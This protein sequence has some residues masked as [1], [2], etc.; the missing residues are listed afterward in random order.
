MPESVTTPA[1]ENAGTTRPASSNRR[2]RYKT[3]RNQNLAAMANSESTF[4]G[5]NKKVAIIGKP[6]EKGVSFERFIEDVLG[7]VVLEYEEGDDLELLLESQSDDFEKAAD[8][9]LPELKSTEDTAKVM[10]EA[11]YA[12]YRK[13]EKSYKNN[14]KKLFGLIYGQCT[15]TLLASIKSQK[16]YSEKYKEKDIVWLL[17]IIKRL[18]VGIDDNANDLLTAHDAL[19]LFYNMVQGRT[20]TNE[21]YMERFKETWN[22]A[23]ATSGSIKCLVPEVLNKSDKYKDLDEEAK[24]EATKALYYFIHA[25]RLRYG[26]KINQVNAAVV[27]G[28]DQYPTTLDKAYAILTETQKQLE[29][30][31][32]RSNNYGNRSRNE[33]GQSNYQ[34]NRTIPDGENIVMG[35]DRR[36]FNVQCNRCNA[37]GHYASACPQVSNTVSIKTSNNISDDNILTSLCYI[38]DTGSTHTTVKDKDDLINLTNLFKNKVLNMRSSTGNILRYHQKGTLQ[39]FGVESYYNPDTAANILAFHSLSKLKDAYMLYDSRH[40][41]CFRLI[42]KNGK[43]LQFQNCGDGLY[44]FVNPIHNKVFNHMG[45]YK[46]DILDMDERQQNNIKSETNKINEEVREQNSIK[47]ETKNT[48]EKEQK[49]IIKRNNTQYLQTIKGNE[50][51]MTNKERDRAKAA[52]ELQEYLGWPSTQEYINIINGNE[53]RNADVTVDDIKRALTLFGEPT[54]CLR[55]KMTRRRPLSHDTL[56]FVQQPLPIQLHDKRVELY[57]DLYKFAGT[58]FIIME[59]SRIKYIDIE[60][61]T[62]QSIE[63]LI[64]HVTNEIDKYSARGLQISGVHVDNQFYKS[65]FER[66]IKPA[67]LIPYAAEEHVSIIERR[68][69]TVKERMRSILSGLPYKALPNVMI[70]GLA[71]K[72]KSML[73]KFPARN[74]GVSKTISPEEI[75]EGKRKMDGNRKRINFGQF[76]EIHDGTTNKADARSVGGIAMYATN[77][78]EGFA[79]MCLDTGKSRHSNNWTIK[80]ITEDIITRVENIAKDMIDTNELIEELDIYELSEELDSAERKENILRAERRAQ[81]EEIMEEDRNINND[82]TEHSD[83][84]AVDVYEQSQRNEQDGVVQPD[85]TDN[86]QSISDESNQNESITENNDQNINNELDIMQNNENIIELESNEIEAE[87]VDDNIE[88]VVDENISV[89]NTGENEQQEDNNN[90]DTENRRI[91]EQNIVDDIER[92]LITEEV[93]DG[94]QIVDNIIEKE[95]VDIQE[96]HNTDIMIN[97]GNISIEDDDLEAHIGKKDDIIEETDI[98][99]YQLRQRARSRINEMIG[100]RSP[101]RIVN[102]IKERVKKRII[103]EKTRYQ[104]RRNVKSRED[105]RKEIIEGSSNMN[106]N[107]G[108]QC[109]QRKGRGYSRE[110]RR[111]RKKYINAA[112]VLFGDS[113]NDTRN[114]DEYKACVNTCFAQQ[115]SANKG[116]KEYGERAVTAM[117]KE[118][119]QLDKGAIEG[120]PVIEAIDYESISKDERNK[121]LDA[122]NLIELKRDG[123]L[124]GRSC[125]NGSKQRSYLT[126]YDSVASPTVSLEGFFT[127]LLIG[128]YE[129]REHISFDVP[130]AFLQA[131]MPD[132]KLVLLRFRGRMADMLGEVNNEYYKHIKYE[133]GKKVL[134]VKVIRAIYG[135]IESALQWYKLFTTTL[136]D[137]GF[138]INPYDKYIANKLVNGSQLTVAWHVDDC[139]ASHKDSK[140][141]DEFADN[142]IKEFGAMTITKGMDHDFLGMRIG[143]NKDKSVTVDMRAQIRQVIEEF[144]KFDTSDT[145]VVTPAAHH[146]FTVNHECEKLDKEKSIAFHS[147]TSKLGYIMKRGRPDIETSIS[148]LMKRVSKSDKDDWNKLR[149]IIGFLK[150]SIDDVRVIGATSITEIMTFV[151]SSYAVHDNMRS[152]TGGLVSFGI[153]AAHTRSTTSKINVKSATESELVSASEYLPYTIW[154]KHFMEEQGYKI[155]DNV[156]YQD[157]KSAILM[158]INGRNSCTGNSRHI[159]IRYF[160][161]KDRVANKE[162]RVEYLPTHIML[163][164][165]FTKPLQGSQFRLLREFIMGWR[166]MNELVLLKNSDTKCED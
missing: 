94:T 104:P 34:G 83:N 143:F 124:K 102:D 148:F 57:V 76:A 91:I 117:M 88:T 50:L 159:H 23:V 30:E 103:P 66:A 150:G 25:D 37:W 154:F 122:V 135:C 44:T 116:F 142:M 7:F 108:T 80:P 33:Q 12:E 62:S 55:G 73:N 89:N 54:A 64:Q 113:K 120:K 22:A 101:K 11:D 67:N 82:T 28:T 60:V 79:F 139:L 149:R 145:A 72:V 40:G 75:I 98:T 20:E 15:P 10:F 86:E 119:V 147:I 6:H 141:L 114:I 158:E 100:N 69:R 166:P 27:L 24:V 18:S 1:A 136:Q 52:R 87:N 45:H 130:G 109:F 138:T 92:Q 38:L 16:Q 84:I 121:A 115:F 35:T 137:M 5:K 46:K 14:K 153:G 128:A 39:P 152:H 97:T 127:T 93:Q 43:E 110:F 140:V 132:D 163:A 96:D 155:K 68:I 56:E 134:Y 17:E 85:E 61:A 144:E 133:N 164:D 162:V 125:A 2:P 156:L 165:Y 70:R 95:D 4:V 49:I 126:E 31:R 58:W 105:C 3:I 42:H 129:E 32:L 146:L 19:K 13:R 41:D 51:L 26:T 78:R 36:V 63:H 131:E 71:K 106:K 53:I 90:I 74:G 21:K 111:L 160:W 157:N 47:S 8:T 112:E 9:K 161:M 118:L 151:D 29:R 48:K 99:R 123:R 59:S 77:D 107:I 81:R 65:E